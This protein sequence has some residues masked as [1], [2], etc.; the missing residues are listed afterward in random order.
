MYKILVTGA[1]GFLGRSVVKELTDN[2]Y[3]VVA[4]GKNLNKLNELKNANVE[5]YQGDFT[6][7]DDIVSASKNV[8]YII[9][10]GAKMANWG[11]KEDFF[12]ANVLG[13]SNVLEACKVNNIKRLVYTSSPSCYPNQD[14]Y[15]F[16]EEDYNINN[17]INYYVESKIAAEA[18]VKNQ[19]EV[20]YA[21]IRPRGLCGIGDKHIIPSLIKINSS[22]GMPLFN[23][24]SVLVDL[25]CVEN[26]ALSLRL[27][28]EKDE[29]LNQIYNV[30]NDEPRNI[31]DLADEMLPLLGITPKYCHLPFKL[32]YFIAWSM[33]SV[34]KLFGIYDSS[35]PI[36][37]HDLCT[38]GHSQVF[39]ISKIKNELGYVPK[40]SLREMMER[41]AALE[42]NGE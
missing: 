35:P 20:P 12:K 37:R 17:K 26:V 5:I 32:V 21:I 34:F 2:D 15:S 27:C 13:T 6:N 31:K 7:L 8:D 19:T 23:N 14:S 28:M 33:E 38:I 25:C 36:T 42:R 4:F 40:I 41:Y 1:Y 9:H 18:L 39:D 16:K 22:I 11:R 10:C 29:A 3:Q 30:T 24:G